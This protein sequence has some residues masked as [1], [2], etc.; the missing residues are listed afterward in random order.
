MRTRTITRRWW[1][2]TRKVGWRTRRK[3]R[4]ITMISR[5]MELPW[6]DGGAEEEVEEAQERKLEVE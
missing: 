1:W 6:G 2:R 4:T 3:P 5:T